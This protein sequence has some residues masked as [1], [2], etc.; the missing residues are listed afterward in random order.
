MET[1]LIW[2]KIIFVICLIWP[3]GYLLVYLIDRSKSFGFGFKFFAGWLFG[4]AG[5][6]LDVFGANTM[7]FKLQPW[8]FLLFSVSQIFGFGFMIFLFEKSVPLPR[9]KRFP[10]FIMQK[11][12]QLWQSD[13]LEKAA[14]VFLLLVIAV[15][16]YI[17]NSRLQEFPVAS[18]DSYRNINYKAKTIFYLRDISTDVKSQFYLGGGEWAKPLNDSILK[19]WLAQNVGQFNDRGINLTSQFYY[20]LLLLLFYF[21]L[22]EKS[23]RLFKLLATAFLAFLPPLIFNSEYIPRADWLLGIF[24]MLSGVSLYNYLKGRGNSFYYFSSI[25]LA[26][27]AWTANE[28]LVILFPALVILTISLLVLKRVSVKDFLLCWFFTWLTVFPWA[29]FV[30]IKG[31]NI[32]RVE[33]D[34]LFFQFIPALIA[35]SAI[36]LGTLGNYLRKISSI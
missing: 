28:G 26:F 20:L 3:R 4:L 12:I 27:A 5:F 17:A 1:L 8:L 30:L 22:P 18:F 36:G 35:L 32:W 31:V 14:L 33:P 10:R 29:S 16:L 34:Y 21:L 24:L 19:V 2:L 25:S 23:S 11:L 6:T 9:F 15:Q 7:G 13:K